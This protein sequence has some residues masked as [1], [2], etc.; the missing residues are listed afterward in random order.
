MSFLVTLASWIGALI[1][2]RSFFYIYQWLISY[3]RSYVDVKSAFDTEWALV[4]GANS[5]LGRRLALSLAAQ[6][7]NVIGT[8]RDVSRLKAVQAEVQSKNVEFIPVIAD[9][10]QPAAVQVIIDACGERDVGV[11]IINPA[12]GI[13]GPISRKDDNRIIGSFQLLATSYAVLGRE[14]IVR[15]QKRGNK[16]TV[17]YFTASVGA[18]IVAPMSLVYFSAKAYVSALTKALAIELAGTNVKITAMHPGFFITES[19]FLR[20]FPVKIQRLVKHFA[21]FIASSENIAAAVMRNLGRA[22]AVD[23]AVDS[24]AFRVVQWAAGELPLYFCCRVVCWAVTRFD[25]LLR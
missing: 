15:S 21:W 9:L 7:V 23:C 6:G 19:R 3:I 24:L 22:H 20:V 13:F 2:F 14:F 4:V 25:H 16:P 10:F 18:Q 11:V 12:L 1:V 8:G 17:V 5:G